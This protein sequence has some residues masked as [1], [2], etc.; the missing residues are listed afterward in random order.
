MQERRYG[1]GCIRYAE[2]KNIPHILLCGIFLVKTYSFAE[3][4][5]SKVAQ[6][7]S[8]QVQA[9]DGPTSI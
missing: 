7:V 6:I 8:A 2:I 9:L 5:G 4:D 3:L 1:A